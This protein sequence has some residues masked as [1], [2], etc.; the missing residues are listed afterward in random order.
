MKHSLKSSG[1]EVEFCRRSASDT[2]T[3]RRLKRRFSIPTDC[4]SASYSSFGRPD[5]DESNGTHDHDPNPI[6]LSLRAEDGRN[7]RFHLCFKVCTAIADDEDDA[8]NFIFHLGGPPSHQ[9]M[10]HDMFSRIFTIARHQG[11]GHRLEV[12][13]RAFSDGSA[14][15]PPPLFTGLLKLWRLPA[16]NGKIHIQVSA[17]L[18]LNVNRALNHQR[19]RLRRGQRGAIFRNETPAISRPYPADNLAP[20]A[21]S[22]REH[23]NA[24]SEY[25][26]QAVTALF[27]D[28]R[29]AASVS[30]AMG[31]GTISIT[32]RPGDFSLREVETCWDIGGTGF[33][34]NHV[35]DAIAPALREWG[36]ARGWEGNERNSTVEFLK[37][38]RLGVYAKSDNRLRLEIRHRPPKGKD[39]YTA[40]NLHELICTMDFFRERAA[41]RINSLLGP[42]R[43]RLAACV[44]ERD[45]TAY[46]FEWGACC[47]NSEASKVVLRLLTLEGRIFGGRFMDHIPEWNRIKRKAITHGLL[48]FEGKAYR[49][50][51][52]ASADS[53]FTSLGNLARFP[54]HNTE[55]HPVSESPNSPTPRRIVREWNRIP[56]SPPFFPD[57]LPV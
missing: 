46:A 26:K 51:M 43:A 5:R 12:R 10:G 56:P 1:G 52:P 16:S 20:L 6:P 35:L 2:R 54:G 29:R 50:S 42:L 8:T 31:S 34:A 39:R 47:G 55:T 22:P 13:Q 11:K 9:R 49:P 44:P 41:N 4:R 7:D 24:R 28:V 19:A 27:G 21:L 48:R 53:T 15:L 38:E 57:A 3:V 45:W 40:Q 18:F 23:D 25:I 32:G 17:D 37:S 36:G 30:E 33:D 14:S